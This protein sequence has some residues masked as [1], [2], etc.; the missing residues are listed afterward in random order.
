MCEIV[1]AISK[2]AN[3]VLIEI[4]S[5]I[6]CC[7]VHF[8]SGKSSRFST[9]VKPLWWRTFIWT[10]LALPINLRPLKLLGLC[11]NYASDTKRINSN[12]FLSLIA[13]RMLF[14]QGIQLGNADK[15]FRLCFVNK[16][17]PTMQLFDQF[18]FE[19]LEILRQI[20]HT[21]F[22]SDEIRFSF[23]SRES[24]LVY[25]VYDDFSV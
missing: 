19:T 14:Q 9:G 18:Y 15:P 17:S 7:T 24:L 13:S 5:H 4:P 3:E 8:F 22:L 20:L 10:R 16:I 23:K 1:L 2:L 11:L 25:I 12:L 21:D 6:G